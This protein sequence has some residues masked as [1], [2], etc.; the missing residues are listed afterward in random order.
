M[1]RTYSEKSPVQLDEGELWGEEDEPD[2]GKPSTPR[3]GFGFH[4]VGK[5]PQF[6]RTTC[7]TMYG[8]SL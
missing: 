4:L 3:K 7:F 8:N 6:L 5:S 1:D 2:D